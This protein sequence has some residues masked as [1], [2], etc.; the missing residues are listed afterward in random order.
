RDYTF[1]PSIYCYA[2][3]LNQVF[4]NILGNAID[5]IEED[6]RYHLS[7]DE[8]QSEH[9]D[10]SS[11]LPVPKIYIQ[12]EKVNEDWVTIHI[13]DNGP[14]IP[15]QVQSKL[16]DPFF[17]TKEVGKG[18][19]LGL[20]ISYQIIV[21]KHGGKLWCHSLEGE[22]SEFVIQLPIAPKL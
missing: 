13:A 19:G 8:D 21:E 7:P 4:M 10:Q 11:N 5:A 20:S 1:V 15:E 3:E 14:G 9:P 17:T 16:F 6:D 12:T 22:G 2:G 18:T